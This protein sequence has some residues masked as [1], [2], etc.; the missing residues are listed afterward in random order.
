MIKPILNKMESNGKLI[1]GYT[2]F[3]ILNLLFNIPGQ[4]LAQKTTSAAQS[5][6]YDV[7]V[8]GATPSGISSAINAAREGAKVALI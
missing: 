5:K 7:V 1:S 4:L 2:W 6:V 3:L 8:Y